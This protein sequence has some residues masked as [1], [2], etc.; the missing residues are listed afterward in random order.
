MEG[1]TLNELMTNWMW[2]TFT[3]KDG[4]KKHILTTLSDTLLES[5]GVSNRTDCVYDRTCN[6][7]F[8]IR[9]DAIDVK[10]SKEKPVYS[11]EV[12]N[13]ASRFI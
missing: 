11:E 3:F 12:L 7:F 4:S 13:F 8:Q 1:D 2:V 6:Q 5:V 10:V 9:E